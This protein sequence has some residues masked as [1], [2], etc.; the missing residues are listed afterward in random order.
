MRFSFSY[1]GTLEEEITTQ[2]TE[3][4]V[5]GECLFFFFLDL[6]T[7]RFFNQQLQL[8][9]AVLFFFPICAST[10]EKG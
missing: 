5:L 7:S 8:L 6:Y 10:T 1:T 9:S 3:Q 2:N 4:R